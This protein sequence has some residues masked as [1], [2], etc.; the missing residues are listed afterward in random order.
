MIRDRRALKCC[1]SADL[2]SSGRTRFTLWD[3]FKYPVLRYQILL[4][5]YEYYL[6]KDE[7]QLRMCARLYYRYR[8]HSLSYHL[9]IQIPPNVFGPGL[10]MVHHQGIVVSSNSRVGKNC[11]IHAGVN[12]GAWRGKAPTLGDDVYIGPGAKLIG[13]IMIGD[14]CVIG[15][16]AVVCKSFPPDVTIAGVPASVISQKNSTEVILIRGAQP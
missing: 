2:L 14:R 6:N 5:R 15:A 8:L 7:D 3:S 12:I 16:N 10:C 11:R 13:D 9:G 4:R 1:I